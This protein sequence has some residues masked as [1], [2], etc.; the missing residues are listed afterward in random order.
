LPGERR[1]DRGGSATVT[2]SADGTPALV[3]GAA[4]FVGA[5]LAV[6]L[7]LRGYRVRAL[8]RPTS[9]VGHLAELGVEIVRGDLWN[10][11][12]LV[13][14]ASG[15]RL[16]FHTAARVSDWGPR[17]AFVRANVEG[18]ANIVTAS[19]DA[20]VERFVH[21]S[22]LTVLGLP[23]DRRT[24]DERTPIVP[25]ARGDHYTESKIAG[26][27][28]VRDAHDERGLATTVVRPGAIWGPGDTN[29]VPRIAALLRRGAM[30]YV[31]GGR[32]LL[33]LAH[34]TNL[35]TAL[36]LAAEQ[37]GAAGQLYHVTD[38][39]EISARVAL[40]SLAAA[41]GVAPPRMSVPYWLVYGVAALVEG[42]AR[43]LRR[44]NAPPLTRYGARF[45]AC[46][47]RYDI[48]KAERELDYRP[49]VKFRD[50]IGAG[51]ATETR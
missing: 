30:P 13:P 15:Q 23:R 6:M 40:D 24:V 19:R 47:C 10:P 25:P 46:D 22:S 26:E 42:W 34:V 20:G 1:I 31:G 8:A 9:D 14:A 7:Q 33:G 18:T 11:A 3:T 43:M 36:I 39:E 48:G 37:P 12:S 41:L 49:A 27:R 32:N 45:V 5:H 21:V 28:L 4:G 29:V 2:G 16:V 51:Y 38:G 35:C 44:P 17:E 50:A